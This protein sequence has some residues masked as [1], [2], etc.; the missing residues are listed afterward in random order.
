MYTRWKEI[1]CRWPKILISSNH[2]QFWFLSFRA[3]LSEKQ[4]ITSVYNLH[5]AS[6]RLSSLAR[7]NL[8]WRRNITAGPTFMVS[9]TNSE[10]NLWFSRVT[11]LRINFIITTNMGESLSFSVYL[12]VFLQ[13]LPSC[14]REKKVKFGTGVSCFHNCPLESTMS[15]R[16]GTKQTSGFP[17]GYKNC[18][19][20]RFPIAF[21][22]ITFHEINS[23][24]Y[25]F[26]LRIF[27]KLLSW[28]SWSE[29]M[30]GKTP[31]NQGEK[32]LQSDLEITIRCLSFY[33][34]WN[35]PKDQVRCLIAC[36]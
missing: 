16:M 34:F 5:H 22:K 10:A 27:R 36:S 25:T 32:V 6:L 28:L 9:E 35:W 29:L 7:E 19:T 21:F 8:K 12:W 30:F 18:L 3:G 15:S 13:F 1:S 33:I 4:A 11:F 31:K 17:P 20:L 24:V 2:L 23:R 26:Q 14:S